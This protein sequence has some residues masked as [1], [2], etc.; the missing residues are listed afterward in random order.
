ML[1]E[2]IKRR[3]AVGTDTPVSRI[4]GAPAA[5][6]GMLANGVLAKFNALI[7]RIA[8]MVLPLGAADA[9]ILVLAA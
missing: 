3:A 2:I 8:V 7:M 1:G 5:Q 4:I 9:G 6:S